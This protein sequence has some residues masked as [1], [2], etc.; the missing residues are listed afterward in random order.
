[1]GAGK[2]TEMQEKRRKRGKREV[3][4]KKMKEGIIRREEEMKRSR[5]RR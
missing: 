3:E 1:M 2:E 5:I 4:D